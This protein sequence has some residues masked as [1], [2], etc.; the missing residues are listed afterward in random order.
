MYIYKGIMKVSALIFHVALFPQNTLLVAQ[1]L[2]LF[3]VTSYRHSFLFHLSVH[4]T[5]EADL[6]IS[7]SA[8]KLDAK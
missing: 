4:S 1:I 8:W 3:Y 5:S 7:I 2:F 6:N